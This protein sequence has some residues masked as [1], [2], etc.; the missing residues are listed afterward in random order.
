MMRA[1]SVRL[2][3]KSDTFVAL[4]QTSTLL[5]D[6]ISSFSSS[7]AAISSSLSSNRIDLCSTATKQ[8][9]ENAEILCANL[10]S[11]RKKEGE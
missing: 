1:T 3:V 4:S 5:K 7:G 11:I 9:Q 8:R 2:I 6:S 10:E